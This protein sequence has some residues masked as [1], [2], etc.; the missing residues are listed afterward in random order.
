ML[1][2]GVSFPAIPEGADIMNLMVP[3]MIQDVLTKAK[4][5]EQSAKDTAQKVND[6]IAKRK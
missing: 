3:Q 6:L 1:Q 2:Y 4:T 5:P